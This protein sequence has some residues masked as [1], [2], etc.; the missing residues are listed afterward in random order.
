MQYGRDSV[1]S[2][3]ERSP[4]EPDV[5]GHDVLV[6]HLRPLLEE[7]PSMDLRR[8]GKTGLTVFHARVRVRQRRRADHPGTPAERERG[9]ARAMELGVNYFDTAPSYGDGESERNLGQVLEALRARVYVGTK[10]RL[11]PPDL[12]DVPARSP[13]RS[14]RA[15]AGSGWSASICFSS[16]TGSSRR[17]ARAP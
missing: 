16:T 12:S 6:R 9:V 1:F 13:A 7:D 15:C 2:R 11:D 10:F 14:T 17:A 8:L 5:I 3:G 4:S